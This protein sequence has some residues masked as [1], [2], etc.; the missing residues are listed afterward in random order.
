MHQTPRMPGQRAAGRPSP[1][2]GSVSGLG[3]VALLVTA[4]LAIVAAA[5][6]QS[7]GSDAD[8]HAATDPEAVPAASP[9][10]AVQE[11]AAA[12][13]S[14]F[15][16]LEAGSWHTCG[17]RTDDTIVCWGDN[18]HGQADAPAGQ[19]I[20]VTAGEAH[21]CGLRTDGTITC[22]GGDEYRQTD[23]VPEGLF[24]AVTAGDGHTCGLR[25][26]STVECWPSGGWFDPPGGLF[27]AVTATGLRTCGLRTDSTIECWG[28]DSFDAPPEG[29]FGAV[30]A[31]WSHS[32]GLRVDGTVTCWSDGSSYK[33]P[34]PNE[35][36]VAISTSAYHSCGVRTDGTITCWGRNS[37]GQSRAPDGQFRAVATGHY[38][39]CGLGTDGAITCWG[40]VPD[41]LDI[42][43]PPP[44]GVSIDDGSDLAD[45]AVC[46]PPG[47]RGEHTA[48]FPLPL[49]VAPSTGIL[50][51]AV[52]FIDFPDAA[53]TYSTNFEAERGLPYAE[54]Y[55]EASSYGQLDIEFLP[56]HGWLRAAHSYQDYLSFSLAGISA[57]AGELVQEAIDL[58]D[59]AV[60]FTGISSLMVV[61]PSSLFRGG[62][63]G[64]G[65]A[66]TTVATDEGIL[67]GHRSPRINAFPQEGYSGP[68]HW[69]ATAAHEL[70]HTLGLVDLYPYDASRHTAFTA[71]GDRAWTLNEFGPMR[72]RFFTP[73]G[74]RERPF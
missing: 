68:H 72:L 37:A 39:S 49:W 16:D 12:S 46:R 52:L 61:M 65:F 38:H 34:A 27:S 5:C 32:C 13:S 24:S 41:W 70:L 4:L 36:L 20:A 31:G 8:N 11:V 57:I 18:T 28:P 74:R 26:D 40:T 44:L 35:R 43:T 10:T 45:P 58:A 60:D 3:F 17:L 54:E 22:W 21:S 69:G 30:T 33:P 47:L 6:A 67:D 64:A 62:E 25:T 9:E 15:K 19:Y 14:E 73:A 29:Q 66:Q 51:V 59:P 48:G 71:P 53:P 42:V 63:G 2:P 56:V 23:N 50:R 1:Q 55:L 7:G